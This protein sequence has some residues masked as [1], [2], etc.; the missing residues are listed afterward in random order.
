MA[1]MAV[2]G[3][4]EAL[5]QEIFDGRLRPG[6]RLDEV[7]LGRRFGVSRNTLREG[8]RVLAQGHL[9]EHRPNRGVF[10]RSLSVCEARDIYQARRI[11]E[12]GALRE[13]AL[14]GAQFQADGDDADDDAWKAEIGSIRA[15]LADGRAAAECGDWDAVG[16][17]NSAFHLALVALAGNHVLDRTMRQLLTEMR[18][19]FVVVASARDV[20]E[21]YVDLNEQIATLIEAGQIVRAAVVLEEYLMRA[22]RHL[23]DRYASSV[24]GASR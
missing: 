14:R 7:T 13:A 6:D 2:S 5:R 16:S 8:F 10:V 22:E 11:V 3:L 21:P 24:D 19:L 1:G 17:S 4:V 20:H 12:C 23:L 9:V 18:L 15:V